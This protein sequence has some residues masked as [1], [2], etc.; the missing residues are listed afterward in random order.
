[1]TSPQPP[2]F[3]FTPPMPPPPPETVYTTAPGLP[4]IAPPPIQEWNAPTPAPVSEPAQVV[5]PV[6]KKST[7]LN[8]D[9]TWVLVFTVSIVF[10]LMLA[11]FTASFVAI[12][13][14]AEF[15]GIGEL[16]WV[17]PVF[18]DAAI[19]AYTLSLFIF[20]HRGESTWRTLLGLFGFALLS[21]AANV[22]HTISYW[23]GDIS[24]YQSWIGIVLT[25][26]API[27]V[28]LASEEIARLAFEPEGLDKTS[29]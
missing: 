21:V 9:S 12:Y 17:F 19:L 3:P 29:V 6:R 27:A 15:T 23:E 1:M 24:S 28:L 4:R 22:V 20:K 10:G 26:A 8:L 13:E 18:I 25:A 5:S 7:R 2:S 11:S 16:R 14:V